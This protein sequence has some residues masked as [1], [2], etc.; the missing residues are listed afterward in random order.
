MYEYKALITRVVD[1]DTYDFEIDLGFGITYNDRLRLWGVNTPEV[2]GLERPE[3]LAVKEQV[4][5]LIEGKEVKLISHKRK[6]KYG[7][8][9]AEVWIWNDF[10]DIPYNL[11][12]YLVQHNMAKKVDY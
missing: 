10:D 12:N 4:V 2:R 5:K 7:R 3:G 6:G 1:G 9:V 8:F 11:G